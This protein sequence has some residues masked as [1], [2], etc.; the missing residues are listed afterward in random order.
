M[1]KWAAL[2]MTLAALA[3][4]AG[5]AVGLEDLPKKLT[6]AEITKLLVGK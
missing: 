6:D 4:L 2:A 1:F 5:W 3:V